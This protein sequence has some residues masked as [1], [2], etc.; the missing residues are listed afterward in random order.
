M[1]KLLSRR[2]FWALVLLAAYALAHG[3]EK[4]D[5]KHKDHKPKSKPK[6]QQD[7]KKKSEPKRKESKDEEHT[8]YAEVSFARS[9][10]V[11]LGSGRLDTASPWARFLAPGMWIKA[12]GTW[13]EG[14]FHALDL[15][16]THPVFFSYYLG[17][18]KPLGL[19]SDW[20]EV[21]HSSEGENAPSHRFALRFSAP[22]YE[23]LLL[24]FSSNGRLVA[25]PTGLPLP[26]TI[27]AKGWLLFRGEVRDQ[28][29]RWESVQQ[30]P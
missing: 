26:S 24:V 3:E 17:P 16:V 20:I 23:P 30:F 14:V 2:R 28:T 18:A 8:L 27:P 11:V 13:E 10:M 1:P 12:Q 25:M 5:D 29:L 22:A 7:D 21:W 9:G 15:E 4:K 6:D 19:G